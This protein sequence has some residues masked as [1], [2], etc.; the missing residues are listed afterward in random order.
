MGLNKN[1]NNLSD[2]IC[3]GKSFLALKT[4]WAMIDMQQ[5]LTVLLQFCMLGLQRINLGRGCYLL[6]KYMAIKEI[7]RLKRKCFVAFTI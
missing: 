7:F 5:T 1:G 2:K 4:L 3:V 6:P